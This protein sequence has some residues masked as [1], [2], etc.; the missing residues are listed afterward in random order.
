MLEFPALHI[1][2]PEN[3]AALRRLMAFN[4]GKIRAAN[5]ASILIVLRAAEFLD[6]PVVYADAARA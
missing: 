6:R 5:G 4:Q 1:F 2:L 3:F